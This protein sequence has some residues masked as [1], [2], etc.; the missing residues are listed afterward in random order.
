MTTMQRTLVA[1]LMVCIPAFAADGIAFITNLKGDV[2]VDGNPRP[3]LLSEL[4][5]GQKVTVGK[6]S[7]ASVMFIA[8][9]KEYVLKGPADFLVKDT[10]MSSSSG[11]PPTTRETAWRTSNKV[12]AQAAQTS[13]ASVRMRSL[14][15][16]KPDTAPKLLFPTEGAV[17]T[18]QPTF[19]WRPADAKAQAD[20]A[21]AIVGQE[22]PVHQSKVSG[23]SYRV[24]AKLRPET[25]YA[26]IV[27]VAGNEIGSG[28]FHT[29]SSEA[30]GHVEKRRP[31]D[32]ADFSDKLLFTL[33]LQEMGATQEAHESW[34]HLAQERSDLPELAAFA[35]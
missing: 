16:P 24:P 29:L 4:A 26:W 3:V 20:F 12:L 28:R 2:A 21:L 33:M 13:A 14:A 32:K 23:S 10:E 5:R 15:Q 11:M 34:A 25:E 27:T 9:G 30:L 8:S 7:Q 17:A 35:K 22:K 18:L 31:A 19:R 1:L 6:E